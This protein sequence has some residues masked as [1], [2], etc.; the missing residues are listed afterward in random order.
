M[1]LT[2]WLKV[3]LDSSTGTDNYSPGI[4]VP[5]KIAS[6]HLDNAVQGAADGTAITE[7]TTPPGLADLSATQ[8]EWFYDF[9]GHISFV[10]VGQEASADRLDS[11]NGP[12]TLTTATSGGFLS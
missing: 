9:M 7:N 6:R 11:T 3:T 5:F 2:S 1:P 4:N 12:T 8:T 10:G